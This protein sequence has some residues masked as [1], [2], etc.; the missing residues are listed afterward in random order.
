MV[1]VELPWEVDGNICNVKN[2]ELSPDSNEYGVI[3][4]DIKSATEMYFYAEKITKT[5]KESTGYTLNYTQ[6]AFSDGTNFKY[7]YDFGSNLSN[8]KENNSEYDPIGIVVIPASLSTSVYPTTDARYGKNVIMS[9]VSMDNTSPDTGSSANTLLYWGYPY[10]GSLTYYS[11]IPTFSGNDQ[12]VISPQSFGNL[13]IFTSYTTKNFVCKTNGKLYYDNLIPLVMPC[14]SPL[15]GNV[16]IETDTHYT[17]STYATSNISGPYLTAIMTALATDTWKTA[18]TITNQNTSGN[19]PA[20][21]CC[22]RFSTKGVKS[23]LSHKTE[24]PSYDYT[25]GVTNVWYMPALGEL[26]YAVPLMMN[27]Y[28]PTISKLSEIFGTTFAKFIEQNIHTT[29][30]YSNNNSIDYCVSAYGV[31]GQNTSNYTASVRAFCALP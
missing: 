13:P 21:C 11:T 24:N 17:N 20:F 22:A 27:K 1:Y 26:G 5:I 31:I 29:T 19:Y 7:V 16:E 2:L 8:F 6:V 18:T 14:A 15:K 23:F 3:T 28:N 25:S 30:I 4:V 12:N 10:S 9:L